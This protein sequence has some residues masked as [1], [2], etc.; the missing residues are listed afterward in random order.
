VGAAPSTDVN[1]NPIPGVVVTVTGGL[2]T[3]LN[4]PLDQYGQ[5]VNLTASEEVEWLGGGVTVALC[6]TV[7]ETLFER[8]RVGHEGG[9]GPFFGAIEILPQ[10]DG[11]DVTSVVGFCGEPIGNRTGFGLLRNLAERVLLPQKLHAAA[12]ADRTGGVGGTTRKFS[13]FRAVDPELEVVAASP[14]NTSGT[15]G[16]PVDEP[17]SVLV[18]TQTLQTEI[19]GIDVGFEVPDG[20]PGTITPAEV[21]TNA[22]GVAATTSWVLGAG[23]NT[24][25][26]TP[27]APVPEITFTPT[28][29]T[30]TAQGALPPPEY[31]A[32]DWSYRILSSA[33]ED[34]DWTTFDWPVTETGWSQGT[35]PFGSPSGC[36]LTPQTS[37]P[38]NQ[39]IL[40]RRDFFVPEGTGWADIAVTIDN[41]VRVFVNGVEITDGAQVHENCANTNLLEP[42]TAFAG[43]GGPLIAGGVNQLAILGIDRGV[44]SFIDVEVTLV[45][46][47]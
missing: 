5:T 15:P 1:G 45:E 4:T 46:L 30:F 31:G 37:W 39:V 32:S 25:I 41:D 2:T 12:L 13:P 35:A 20:S 11:D 9:L 28:T 17:P 43:E 23:E 34:E 18:R 16:E 21:T 26:A 40:L 24:V 3:P 33:P 6:V 29:I 10:A 14:T 22:D 7:D 27:E 38:V 36:G 47:D 44:E 19:P 42:F 8:L